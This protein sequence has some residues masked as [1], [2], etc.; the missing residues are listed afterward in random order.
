[1]T[2]RSHPP[3][4]FFDLVGTLV[5]RSGGTFVANPQASSWVLAANRNGVLT[6]AAQF[7]TA[8]DV[9]RILEHTGLGHL[10]DDDLIVM[11]SHLRFPLPD[12][13]A[14]AVAAA[15]A[16]TRIG[17][18]T[19]VS[20]DHALLVAAATAGMRTVSVA[21]AAVSAG[22]PVPAETPVADH[23][24][25]AA[26]AP[27]A[28]VVAE[29]AGQLLAG[30]I[31]EDPGPTFVLRGRVVTMDKPGEVLDD[32]Q[33]VVRAGK[34]AAVVPSGSELPAEY[35]SARTLN[36]NGTIYPGLIDL[37]NHF[38]YNIRPLWPLPK[39]YD[40]RGQWTT[41]TYSAEVSKPV[42]A[43]AGSGRTARSL[44]RY[45]E[46]KALIGGTTTGQGIKTQ[47]RGGFGL[48]RGVMRNVEETDD[49]RLPEAST[50]V[51]DLY[52]KKQDRVEAF[53]RTLESRAAYFYHLAE[54]IDGVSQQR[55]QDLKSNDLIQKSLV[56]IHS[57]GLEAPDLAYMA[58]AGAKVV[59]SPFSN[60]LLYGAT[61]DLAALRASGVVF[62]IGC[63]WAPTGSKNLLEEL[64]VARWVVENQESDFT[65]EELVRAVTVNAAAAAGW[66]DG[67]GRLREGLFADLVVIR[68]TD[69]D[70]WDRLIAATEPEVDLVVIHGKARYGSLENMEALH[71]DPS[72]EIEQWS[73]GGES[74]G[75]DL[76]APASPLNDVSFARAVE[77]LETGM[78]DLPGLVEEA[79]SG[80]NEL[81]ALGLD[82]PAFTVLLDNEYEPD[83]SE[84]P[85]AESQLLADVPMPD[86]VPLDAPEVNA[87]GYWDLV[88]AQ[89]NIQDGLKTYLRS[90]YGG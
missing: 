72:I 79:A 60:M 58:A 52:V 24:A 56:G 53:R 71:G 8:R 31:D 78:A 35:A 80:E 77:V 76:Y 30:E 83:P 88:D 18:C 37:H 73:V 55:F 16:E 43:V 25:L 45:V 67:V 75:F 66:Q 48:Y 5:V 21:G 9:R 46:A 40:N 50:L 69:G 85:D 32:G 34:I 51:P 33:V 20:A 3:V 62:S 47:V 10:F 86:S 17:S 54:G 6:N 87:E 82:A 36:T 57:L 11:A 65:S 61:L 41:P 84:V 70:P 27:A 42:K 29:P 49:P 14:F 89:P 7:R 15:I 13:R 38:A 90:A 59:W 39:R 1:M 19:Y 64:K 4:V 12:R 63:D 68:G 81:L 23:A 22:S 28:T 74:K 2:G 44:V 26:S